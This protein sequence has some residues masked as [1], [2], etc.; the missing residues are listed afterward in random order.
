MA[1]GLRSHE[2]IL[3]DLSALSAS[4]EMGGSAVKFG[5]P[6]LSPSE[7]LS[8]SPTWLHGGYRRLVILDLRPQAQ[9]ASSRRFEVMT[10][11]VCDCQSWCQVFSGLE[12]QA[13][14]CILAEA[15]RQRTFHLHDV[16]FYAFRVMNWLVLLMQDRRKEVSV[17][18]ET[19]STHHGRCQLAYLLRRYQ[20]RVIIC[21]APRLNVLLVP[22][23]QTVHGWN[24]TTLQR[25]ACCLSNTRVHPA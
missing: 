6:G 15:Q 22:F 23:L 3:A 14:T 11:R 25:Q 4:Y 18:Y 12:A 17:S 9:F 16:N 5:Q 10:W 21:P 20:S 24:I 19:L 8:S 2:Q 1:N 13:W 7:N